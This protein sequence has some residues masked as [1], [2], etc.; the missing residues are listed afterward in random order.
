MIIGDFDLTTEK[1][2]SEFNKEYEGRFI[3]YSMDGGGVHL[4]GVNEKESTILYDTD[5]HMFNIDN[6]NEE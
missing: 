2:L 4:R 1:G 3:A 6:N 5:T